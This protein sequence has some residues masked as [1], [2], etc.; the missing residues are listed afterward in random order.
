[1]LEARTESVDNWGGARG[2]RASE[3]VSTISRS[4]N[5]RGGVDDK[6]VLLRMVRSR[7]KARVVKTRTV[8]VVGEERPTETSPH[9]VT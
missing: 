5:K 2:D 3:A 6:D 8:E 4:I 9:R 1:M 7:D